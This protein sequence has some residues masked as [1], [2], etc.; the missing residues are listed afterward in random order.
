MGDID[1]EIQKL[2]SILIPFANDRFAMTNQLSVN[3]DT[4]Y[5]W[6]AEVHRWLI[7]LTELNELPGKYERF[8]GKFI[9]E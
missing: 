3:A 8:I 6:Q 9:R 7:Y 4:F 5:Q 2:E 1:Q